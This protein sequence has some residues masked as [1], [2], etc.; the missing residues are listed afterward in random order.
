[1]INGQMAH[2]C[3]DLLLTH[4]RMISQRAEDDQSERWRKIR[5]DLQVD[6]SHRLTPTCPAGELDNNALNM[7]H[8]PI[9]MCGC[10]SFFILFA[11]FSNVHGIGTVKR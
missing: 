9:F 3:R 2:V 8:F 4:V 6:A 10:G 1:M 7:T 11:G 5:T